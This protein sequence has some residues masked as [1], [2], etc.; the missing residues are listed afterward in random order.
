MPL[1]EETTEKSEKILILCVDRDN[2]VGKKTGLIES[3]RPYGLCIYNE[4]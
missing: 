4:Y 1:A 2:D 3:K